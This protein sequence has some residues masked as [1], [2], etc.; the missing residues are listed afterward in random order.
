MNRRGKDYFHREKNILFRC[1]LVL[2][3]E[4]LKKDTKSNH[5]GEKNTI[6][7]LEVRSEPR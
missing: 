1:F 6:E 5:K 4:P 2:F 3:Y 7:F